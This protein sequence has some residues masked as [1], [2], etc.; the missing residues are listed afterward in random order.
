MSRGGLV[1]FLACL[2]AGATALWVMFFEPEQRH[3]EFLHA[4][5]AEFKS[6]AKKRPPTLTR[7]QWENIVAW[8]LNA[9]AN[10]LILAR[11]IPQAERNQF[12]AELRER[13]RRP[14]ELRDIDW[15]WDELVRLTSWGRSYSEMFRP[16][17]PERL[18][19]FEEGNDHWGIDVD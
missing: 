4:T 17:T 15:I 8:T 7:K 12:L 16:T 11:N 13:L 10:C 5:K 2:G 18:K 9:H 1:A 3:G 19:E 14:V 6:L